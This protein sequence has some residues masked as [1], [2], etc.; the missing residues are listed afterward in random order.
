MTPLE[1]LWDDQAEWSQ[2]T[3]G[4]DAERGPVGPIRHLALECAEVEEA[5]E[6]WRETSC[7]GPAMKSMRDNLRTELA[8]CLLLLMDASRRAGVNLD[9]LVA[10]AIDK[11][12]RNKARKWPVSTGDTHES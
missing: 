10:A 11:H 5:W 7:G 8:D 2:R 3:F 6:Q 9:T 1:A 4:S 12:Q